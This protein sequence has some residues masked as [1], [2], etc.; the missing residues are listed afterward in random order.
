M[1]TY[2]IIGR[3]HVRLILISAEQDVDCS[4]SMITAT[5]VWCRVLSGGGGGLQRIDRKA[6]E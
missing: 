3:K 6:I 1:P 2:D 5:C 4:W